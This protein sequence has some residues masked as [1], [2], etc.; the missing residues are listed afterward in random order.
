MT[1]RC[2][3]SRPAIPTGGAAPILVAVGP[4]VERF[5]RWE[6]TQTLKQIKEIPKAEADAIIR[7]IQGLPAVPPMPVEEKVEPKG[8]PKPEEK[9]EP[10]PEEKAPEKEVAPMPKLA[11]K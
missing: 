2:G 4:K 1:G 3:D 7:T 10:K 6:F 5:Y 8:E 11:A 9:P